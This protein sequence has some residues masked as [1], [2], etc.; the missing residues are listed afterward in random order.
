[1]PSEE[2]HNLRVQVLYIKGFSLKFSR[3]KKLNKRCK[4][5]I[6][7]LLYAVLYTLSKIQTFFK[8]M[9]T[10]LDSSKNPKNYYYFTSDQPTFFFRRINDAFSDYNKK[11]CSLGALCI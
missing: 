7:S 3:P 10:F 8:I 11:K 4:S 2:L 5:D 9:V 1:M 6:R